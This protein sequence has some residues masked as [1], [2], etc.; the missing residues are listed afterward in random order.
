MTLFI[1]WPVSQDAEFRAAYEAQ[2]GEAV[3]ENPI[4]DGTHYLIGTSRAFESDI[5]ALRAQ[6]LHIST[7]ADLDMIGWTYLSQSE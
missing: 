5:D 6:G 2:T 7:A 4:T 3:Q 1:S